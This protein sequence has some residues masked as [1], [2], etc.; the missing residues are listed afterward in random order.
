MVDLWGAQKEL[1]QLEAEK[2]SWKKRLFISEG[3]H[4]ILQGHRD[5]EQL[6]ESKLNIGT[7]KKGIGVGY[8]SKALRF[9]LRARDLVS[10]DFENSYKQ[11]YT[12]LEQIYGLK[13]D[14]QK[15]FEELKVIRDWLI[16]NS[17][18]IDT[19]LFLH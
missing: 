17:M 6:F 9:G 16:D 10:R 4:L 2:I 19:S 11:F 3:S 14:T 1:K 8:A 12:F 13:I 7:T 5:V 15:E 18:V